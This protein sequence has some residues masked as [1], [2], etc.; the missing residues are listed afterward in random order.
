MDVQDSKGSTALH[1]ACAGHLTVLSVKSKS[2]LVILFST[3]ILQVITVRLPTCFSGC[4]QQ[5]LSSVTG[6]FAV[7]HRH[8]L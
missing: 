2:S 6:T 8:F 1:L 5:L 4:R 7:V 3:K